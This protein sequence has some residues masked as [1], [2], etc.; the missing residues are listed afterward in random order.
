M[1]GG[2]A[3]ELRVCPPMKRRS[4]KRRLRPS[5]VA[6]PVPT[7]RL[8]EPLTLARVKSG[9]QRLGLSLV[10]LIATVSGVRAQFTDWNASAGDWSKPVNWTAGVPT[11]SLTVV[12]GNGISGTAT[13]CRAIRLRN[14]NL[15]RSQWLQRR[16]RTRLRYTHGRQRLGARNR[17]CY[18]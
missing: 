11:A 2:S 1:I 12:I 16:N 4:M 17:R 5:F 15:E 18:G 8:S 9:L 6:R 7:T 13:I 3:G 10:L 14:I